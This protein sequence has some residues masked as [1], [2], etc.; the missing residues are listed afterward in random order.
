LLK[1][2]AKT[3]GGQ[4]GDEAAIFHSQ[5]DPN[6][7]RML[8]AIQDGKRALLARPRMDMVGAVPVPQE[9]DFGRTF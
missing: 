5:D 7:R 9:R 3:A 4:A 8:E 1:Y 2:L 6:Y